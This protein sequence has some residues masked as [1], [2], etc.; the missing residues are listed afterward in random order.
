MKIQVHDIKA[1]IPRTHHPD[2]RIKIGPVIIEQPSAR[3]HQICY[4]SDIGF[5]QSQGVRIGHHHSGNRI[6]QKGLQVIHIDPS[7][8]SGFDLHHI[9]A[10]DGSRCRVGSVCRIGH[11]HLSAG[12][13]PTKEMIMLHKHETGQF[14]VRSCKWIESECGHSGN[15]TEIF[16]KFPIDLYASFYRIERLKG[17]DVG[18]SRQ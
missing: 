12:D 16:G 4:F 10:A 14:S 11:N 1:H 7:V 18:K 5:E 6:I 3:V 8:R 17:M 9:E 13:I 15:G 2:E